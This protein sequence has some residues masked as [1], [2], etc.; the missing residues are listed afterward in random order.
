MVTRPWA[1]DFSSASL[2]TSSGQ[3]PVEPKSYE[4]DPYH[5]AKHGLRIALHAEGCRAGQIVPVML[6]VVATEARKV[7]PSSVDWDVITVSKTDVVYLGS[8]HQ[9]TMSSSAKTPR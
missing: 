1:V 9:L 4:T 7:D 3:I 5:F 8:E 2:I 6:L